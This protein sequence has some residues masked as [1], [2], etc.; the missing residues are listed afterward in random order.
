MRLKKLG[1]RYDGSFV[2]ISSRLLTARAQPDL[3][4]VHWHWHCI[5]RILLNHNHKESSFISYINQLFTFCWPADILILESDIDRVCYCSR[6]GAFIIRLNTNYNAQYKNN[7]S[8][9]AQHT[10]C[11]GVW[12][13]LILLIGY[14]FFLEE[15]RFLISSSDLPFVSGTN[16]KTKMVPRSAIAE[17]MK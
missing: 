3:V 15:K 6:A 10:W 2:M 11:I 8:Q 17:K 1:M 14:I 12:S 9:L 5:V 4:I 13:R 7:L 16:I